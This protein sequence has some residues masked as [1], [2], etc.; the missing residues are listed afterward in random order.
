MP[1][2]PEICFGNFYAHLN[3]Q[4][5]SDSIPIVIR[6]AANDLRFVSLENARIHHKV[7]RLVRLQVLLSVIPDPRKSMK[8][9][10]ESVAHNLKKLVS[11]RTENGSLVDD[12]D[13]KYDYL[14][15]DEGCQRTCRKFKT[16]R[17]R[18]WQAIFTLLERNEGHFNG[19]HQRIQSLINTRAFIEFTIPVN[20]RNSVK[21]EVLTFQLSLGC[22]SGLSDKNKL[23]LKSTMPHR[24]YLDGAVTISGSPPFGVLRND[25]SYWKKIA[26]Y[27]ARHLYGH[28]W[29]DTVSVPI[30]PLHTL[31]FIQ[32][33]C[34][35]DRKCA[36]KFHRAN[37]KYMKEISTVIEREL[38]ELKVPE[39]DLN[40]L[41][42]FQ[43][44]GLGSDFRV[45]E[46][47]EPCASSFHGGQKIL[48]MIGYTHFGPFHAWASNFDVDELL[49]DETALASKQGR[50]WNRFQSA[51]ERF[52]L[53]KKETN[54]STFYATW[55]DFK[56]LKSDFRSFTARIMKG[57]R[58]AFMP[59]DPFA[60][61]MN[62]SECYDGGGKVMSHYSK[63]VGLLVHYALRL[64]D[65]N[66][67]GIMECKPPR[68]E[69]RTRLFRTSTNETEMYTWHVREI[70]RQGKCVYDRRELEH[71]STCRIR[72][73]SSTD[74]GSAILPLPRLPR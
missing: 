14:I 71:K 23:P 20:L 68:T 29:Y 7:R 73:Q 43:F 16:C 31:S 69:R 72:P 8:R 45:S 11:L 12:I 3:S 1:Y 56:V 61:F 54:K 25:T 10:I 38:I 46:I 44:C 66:D 4:S 15:E 33:M 24:Q 65:L 9:E 50:H 41:I 74:C 37:Y 51:S 13:I 27:A 19:F 21:T 39:T 55:M 49:V 53:L 57:E 22:F 70:P 26:H 17:V 64:K 32:F 63:T 35:L 62:L 42:I 47:E 5:N 60:R 30:L 58:V 2:D 18:E 28:T 36:S 34:G 52:D 59:S 40:R 48:G 6:E 67:L